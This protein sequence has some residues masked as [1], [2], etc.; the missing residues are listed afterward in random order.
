MKTR[1]LAVAVVLAACSADRATAPAP[2]WDDDVEPIVAA[3]C[4]ECHSGSAPAAGFRLDSYIDAIGCASPGNAPVVLPA[5]S[6]APIVAA[7]D[8]P[9]HVGLL[10]GDEQATLLAW[11]TASAPAFSANVHTPDIVDPRAPGFHGT[12]LRAAWW[13]PMLDPSDPNACGVCH[14]G[15]PSRPASVTVGAPDAPSCTSCHDQPGGVLACGTCHGTSEHAYP[16]RDPCF[17]PNDSGGAHAAHVESNAF[18]TGGLPCSTCHPTPNPNDVISGTH[19]D[20]ALEIAFDPSRVSPEASWDPTSAACAVSC[21][22]RGGARPRP[23]WNDTTPVGCNDC[24]GSPP[25]N[26]YAGPCNACHAEANAQGTALSGG[27]LHMNGVVDL[28]DGS[29]T[30]GACH[31]AGD[32]PWPRDATHQAHE[33]PTISEPVA[34]GDCHV[35]PTSVLSPGHL[36]SPVA[37]KFSG[38]ALDRGAIPTWDGTRCQNVACHGANLADPPGEP[39]WGDASAANCGACHGIPP[40]EHTTALDCNRSTCHGNEV[41]SPPNLSI[42]TSGLSLHVNGVID[43][44]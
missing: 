29:G 21:H 35:V 42:T 24:H 38:H 1:V 41:T 34:C 15:A 27:P 26:H 44:Q 11:V 19:G 9:P 17:F 40:T 22:D 23:T 25:A 13:K 7:L 4:V 33:S 43:V 20:G 3:K 32:D 2:T 14:D 12:T 30:C 31:G 10:T 39:A 8:T 6:A 37:I 36:T 16:P 18:D 5:G 28:G